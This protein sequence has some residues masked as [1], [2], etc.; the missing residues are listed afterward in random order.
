MTGDGRNEWAGPGT[1][2]AGIAV[3]SE[4]MWLPKPADI[5]LVN[6]NPQDIASLIPVWQSY[7][8]KNDSELYMEYW[9]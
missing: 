8:S 2:N 3:G 4:L 9:L 7:L 5:I 6:S 1:A